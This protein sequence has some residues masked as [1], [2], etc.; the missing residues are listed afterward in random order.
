MY[1]YIYIYRYVIYIYIYIYIYITGAETP[2]LFRFHREGAAVQILNMQ[3]NI[4]QTRKLYLKKEGHARPE[5][6]LTA[7]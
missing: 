3:Y 5:N 1:V 6:R 4:K 7:V 2:P